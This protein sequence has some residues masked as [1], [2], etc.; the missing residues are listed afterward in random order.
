MP[1]IQNLFQKNCPQY[2]GVYYCLDKEA[3]KD[4]IKRVEMDTYSQRADDFDEQ[5]MLNLSEAHKQAL[6]PLFN[7]P[8]NS[9]ILEVGGGDGRFAFY[10]MRHGLAVIESDIALGSVAKTKQVAEKN[11]IQNGFFAVI[12]A[13]DLPFKNQT[14]DAIYMVASLHH[15]PHPQKAIA[16]FTRVLKKDGQLL[17][18]REPASWQYI[19]FWPFYKIARIILR[20]KNK[21]AVSLADD[22]TFGFSPRKIK[23]LLNHDY[24]NVEIKPVH[25]LGKVYYNAILLANKLT[26]KNY[27][28]NAKIKTALQ[29]IDRLIARMPLINKL[30]WDWDIFCQK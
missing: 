30:S 1:E 29:K 8:K 26:G 7:L 21:N 18:L 5:K 24:S 6:A 2:N 3:A 19:I 20:R 25:Y 13:E 28:E 11:N 17:I 16:E 22:K 10:L 15:L 9:V 12:D 4:E 27:Q 14:L 23:K